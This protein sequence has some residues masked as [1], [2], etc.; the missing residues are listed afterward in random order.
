[1]GDFGGFPVGGLPGEELVKFRGTR[2]LLTERDPVEG[3]DLP[4][5]REAGE[6][7][8]RCLGGVEARWAAV[9]EEERGVSG[10]GEEGRRKAIGEVHRGEVGGGER[11]ERGGGERGEVGGGDR[12]E[13]RG[14]RGGVARREEVGEVGEGEVDRGEE[15]LSSS[16]SFLENIAA[17]PAT[18]RNPR[19]ELWRG[20]EVRK[21]T[22]VERILFLGKEK[23][24]KKN[25]F[26]VLFLALF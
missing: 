22:R 9:G 11:G 12:W 2:G 3:Q 15:S 8:R 26:F 4:V 24:Q 1:M 10:S 19:A 13:E 16:L 6:V 25:L 14:E 7:G 23:K 21:G 17:A 18:A 20:M 5:V